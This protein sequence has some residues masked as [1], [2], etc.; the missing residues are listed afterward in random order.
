MTALYEFELKD[1]AKKLPRKGRRFHGGTFP[2]YDLTPELREKAIALGAK[3]VTRREMVRWRKLIRAHNSGGDA[4][5]NTLNA[6][7]LLW[8]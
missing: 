1:F 3:T 2:H 6:M 7:L 4:F 8:K 5:Q